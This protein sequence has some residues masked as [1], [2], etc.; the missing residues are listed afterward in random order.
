MMV[1]E[2]GAFTAHDTQATALTLQALAFGLPA[3]VLIK[4]FSSSFFAR[5]DTSTPVYTAIAGIAVD[6]GLSVAL[7]G[8]FHQVGIAFATAMA[9]WVNALWLGYLLWRQG[10][11]LIED[12][13]KRF[14][15]RMILTCVSTVI[16]LKA[17]QF[18]LHPFLLGGEFMRGLVVLGIVSGGLF[19]FLLLSHVIGALKFHD[20]KL[21]FSARG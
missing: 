14:G 21:M 11:L 18:S 15:S 6:I 10:H 19:G 1:F 17:L 9:A 4:V 8:T 3:Y 13:L 5:Q 2:R 16:L 20:L 7:M 12:R